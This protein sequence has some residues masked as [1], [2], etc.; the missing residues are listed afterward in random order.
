MITANIKKL[1]LL[2][3]VL[4]TAGGAGY[5]YLHQ[6]NQKDSLASLCV[7]DKIGETIRNNTNYLDSINASKLKPVIDDI[8]KVSNFDKSSTC[9][10]I[11]DKYY[12][13]S[14][15]SAKARTYLD[16]LKKTYDGQ[17]YGDNIKAIANSPEVLEQSVKTLEKQK[18]KIEK[19]AVL[20][21]AGL[22]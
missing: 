15:D 18:M 11:V 19:N 20:I 21:P 14:G 17:G 5:Y 1:V 6:Q 4:V 22:P 16:K 3:I 13:N 8:L 7:K 12:I 10:Y 2:I 9:L